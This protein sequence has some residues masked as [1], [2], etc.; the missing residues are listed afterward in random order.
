[1]SN[2]VADNG[3]DDDC[4]LMNSYTRLALWRTPWPNWIEVRETA[5]MTTTKMSFGSLTVLAQVHIGGLW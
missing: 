2:A 1:M 5:M 3:G 4:A